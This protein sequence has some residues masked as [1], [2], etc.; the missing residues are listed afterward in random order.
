MTHLEQRWKERI[1][2]KVGAAA[3]GGACASQVTE[4]GVYDE[5]DE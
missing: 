5:D 2:N 4:E 1:I 3:A